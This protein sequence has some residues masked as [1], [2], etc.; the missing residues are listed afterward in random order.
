MDQQT[1]SP[2]C[3]VC[4]FGRDD[5]WSWTRSISFSSKL[6]GGVNDSRKKGTIIWHPSLRRYS[7]AFLFSPV[8]I[9]YPTS[10]CSRCIVVTV[11]E[12]S[13]GKIHCTYIFMY[14]WHSKLHLS[15]QYAREYNRL[16][17]DNAHDSC[18]CLI[19]KWKNKAWVKWSNFDHCSIATIYSNRCYIKL[20]IS[21]AESGTTMSR[22]KVSQGMA[23][24]D[25]SSPN[26]SYAFAQCRKLVTDL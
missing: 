1:I 18:V 12:S 21:L 17:W 26:T 19:L 10:F 7:D 4:W 22:E 3:L 14:I 6:Q 16:V 23:C 24:K 13:N 20:P 9:S 5:C 2:L 11:L 25:A 15:I 8:W